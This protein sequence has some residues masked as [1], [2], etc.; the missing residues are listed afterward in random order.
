MSDLD[1]LLLSDEQ[2]KRYYATLADRGIDHN[3]TQQ[4]PRR[5]PGEPI[6]LCSYQEPL[7]FI[8]RLT[9][10]DT[11]HNVVYPMGLPEGDIDDDVLRRAILRA[12]ERQE[13]LR[14]TFRQDDEAV[15]Q[16][17]HEQPMLMYDRVDLT[18][19]P[20]SHR[21][22][23]GW[24]LVDVEAAYRFD[25][26]KGPLIKFTHLVA[27]PGKHVL[28]VSLHHIICDTWSVAIIDREVRT[29]L[30]DLMK[31]KAWTLPPVPVQFGDYCAWQRSTLGGP[32]YERHMA[33]WMDRLRDAPRLQL[34]T[35]FPV[36]EQRT[37]AANNSLVLINDA[38]LEKVKAFARS[39]GVTLYMLLLTAFKIMLARHTGQSD[40]IVGT[41]HA[42]R[43]HGQM[44][45]LIGFTINSLVMRTN[46]GGE[47]DFRTAVQRARA[48][49][50]EAHE[51]QY[52]PFQA[53]VEQLSAQGRSAEMSRY[54]LFRAFFSIQNIRWADI[55][56][57]QIN[58]GALHSRPRFTV[59]HPTTKYDI[60]M[61]LR[62]RDG[63]VLGGLEYDVE[64]FKLSRIERMIRHFL[65]ILEQGITH[66]ETGIHSL[67]MMDSDELSALATA[68]GGATEPPG[69]D[70]VRAFETAAKTYGPLL[71]LM[72][73]D[74]VSC[75]TY[76]E[77]FE[78]V[79]GVAAS[80][81]ARGVKPGQRVGLLADR[82][83]LMVVAVLA[84]LRCGAVCVAM[85]SA[86]PAERSAA[87]MQAYGIEWLLHDA[88]ADVPA[89]D[90]ARAATLESLASAR[91]DAPR[92]SHPHPLATAFIFLTSG[93]TG[94]PQ[95]VELT[96][97]GVLHGQIPGTCVHSIGPGNRLL[98][99]A[100][101]SSARLI[102][103]LLW[104]LINGASVVLTKPSGHQDPEYLAAQLEQHLISHWSV[105]PQ[106]L[107]TVLDLDMLSRCK[108]L[109][110]V[111][112]VG[113]NLEQSLVDRFTGQ[114]N[115]RLYNTY[116]QTEACPVSFEACTAGRVAGRV[117]VGGAAPGVAVHVLG[118]AL[119]PLPVGV[120][121][122]VAVS[123]GCLALGYAGR[124][125]ATAEKFVPDPF[126]PPGS[127]M[128]LSGDLAQWSEVGSLSLIGRA[129]L[130][131]KIRGYRID[132][133]D[134]EAT[135]RTVPGVV[136]AAVLAK[137]QG[138]EE[139]SIVAFVRTEAV[140]S[141][142][143][144]QRGKIFGLRSLAGQP[145]LSERAMWPE[146]LEAAL[147]SKLP[148][149]ML[150]SRIVDVDELPQGRTGKLDR[151]A[152]LALLTELPLPAHSDGTPQNEIEV[153]LVEIWREVL[154]LP[155]S[156]TISRF[157][158][159]FELGGHSLLAVKVVKRVQ[160]RLRTVISIRD[161]FDAVTIAGLAE[162]IRWEQSADS[163]DDIESEAGG[164][165]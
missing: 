14:T 66:P 43:E 152:L 118:S 120:A 6:P 128:Y 68:E 149:Y 142:P 125:A 116:A 80:L 5:K 115:A 18:S 101:V 24:K 88:D 117:P 67:A 41:P 109:K 160:A 95:A 156:R 33:Y 106:V 20:E 74:G 146:Q 104:P 150:P 153:A 91:G 137:A 59:P 97:A 8:D 81:Q 114:S 44:R 144:M 63:K 60:Y 84:T 28:L 111:Y 154:A 23:A 31:G 105:V 55:E 40:I 124:P 46:L 11:A 78:Q 164:T 93:S 165:R 126:G 96:H 82:S 3:G 113:Q 72:E 138:G 7:W 158:S 94:V 130:R 17:V 155:E 49:A 135:L 69:T 53:V 25:L 9:D 131:V 73:D 98:L 151:T 48:T 100:P 79:A 50:L 35:D 39:E 65:R 92:A 136:D 159:F 90:A 1:S 108:S 10:G 30:D 61:Y 36:P 64:L 51:H 157:D 77:L 121:G 107:A 133:G 56:L 110:L 162:L 129:D 148:Y 26:V 12:I 38:L 143:L 52:V 87:V 145:K 75:C 54:S 21:E 103:E 58:T 139:P 4:I 45:D 102:G 2:L 13:I 161:V 89:H 71:A 86:A 141:E 70:I 27:M 99:T 123:G 34:P 163:F 122:Q 32:A 147:Q 22:A 83:R 62:E 16:V 42:N 19:L 37:H 140:A 119:E 47:P 76:R 127:R 29:H 85:D 57:P 112:C 132:L 134:I 15:V